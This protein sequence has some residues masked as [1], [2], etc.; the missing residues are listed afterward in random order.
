MSV[1]FLSGTDGSWTETLGASPPNC[2]QRQ[3]VELVG[4]AG[5]RPSSVGREHDLLGGL[6]LARANSRL[7][8]DAQMRAAVGAV[9]P[10][11]D[12]A[13]GRRHVDPIGFPGKVRPAGAP[14]RA[15]QGGVAPFG[16]NPDEVEHRSRVHTGSRRASRRGA[17][18]ATIRLPSGVQTGSR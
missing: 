13:L 1:S 18:R 7:A 16:G 6:G 8:G 14:S 2:G 3:Q 5:Q 12:Q 17:R 15:D 10:H 4:D 9:E 11:R